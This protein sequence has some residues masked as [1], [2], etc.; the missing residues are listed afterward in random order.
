[1]TLDNRILLYKDLGGNYLSTLMLDT[2]TTRIYRYFKII[3]LEDYYGSV[4]IACGYDQL[5]TKGKIGL[6]SLTPSL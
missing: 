2:T 1:M 3:L 5:N 4:L 6:Y